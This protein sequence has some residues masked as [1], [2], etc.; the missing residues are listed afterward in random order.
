MDRHR[1]RAV[2]EEEIDNPNSTVDKNDP[3]WDDLLTETT[4][5]ADDELSVRILVL[6][7]FLSLELFYIYFRCN[8]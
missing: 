8:F 2:T 6:S 5:D 4:S 1:C 3:M 7:K